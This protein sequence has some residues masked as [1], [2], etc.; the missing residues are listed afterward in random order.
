MEAGT[1]READRD[2]SEFLVEVENALA[3]V[4]LGEAGEWIETLVDCLRPT[5]NDATRF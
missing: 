2:I 4:R 3:N 5:G 1:A